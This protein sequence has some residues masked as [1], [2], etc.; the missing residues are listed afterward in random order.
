MD[1]NIKFAIHTLGCKVNQYESE[2]IIAQLKKLGWVLV[3]FPSAEA[4]AHIINTCT[5]TAVA[6]HKS[7]QLIRRAVS[8]SPN[9]VVAVTGCYAESDKAEIEE[10]DGVDL[11]IG[12]GEKAA[13]AGLISDRLSLDEAGR[14]SIPPIAHHMEQSTEHPAE[15][16]D[17]HP[18]DRSASQFNGS[19]SNKIPAMET[20]SDRSRTRALVKV[21]DGCVNFCT[22]C[23]VPYV[24]GEL[25]YKPVED[26]VEEVSASVAAGAREI[27]LTGIHLGL[28][29][30]QSKSVSAKKAAQSTQSTQAI[31]IAQAVKTA[32]PTKLIQAVL[33]KSGQDALM[34]LKEIESVEPAV[35]NPQ[36]IPKA[37]PKE[38]TNLS[39]LI[40]RLI[41]IT[42]I[43]RIR[44]SSIELNEVTPEL[45]EIMATSG[46]LQSFTY[47]VAKRQR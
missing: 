27:V 7:R 10:I 23:I 30:R 37:N 24:R 44:L 33:Y 15:R 1:R 18:S 13:L 11:V 22:Y 28:Y 19:S 2:K 20:H 43:G 34:E 38:K 17:A 42:D 45:V 16:S 39:A 32:Q 40:K 46:K 3:P 35:Q 21:Q 12:N 31:Q 29:G 25:Q 41:E 47:T 9:G 14:G 5:V 4:N 6:N 8:A 36:E 26:V